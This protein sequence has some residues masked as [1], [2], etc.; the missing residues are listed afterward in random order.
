MPNRHI[1]ELRRAIGQL[2]EE[3]TRRQHNVIIR[4]QATRAAFVQLDDPPAESMK[5]LRHAAFL[6][7]RTSAK[8]YQVWL[9]LNE[10]PDLDFKRRLKEGAGAD[11]MATGATR[12]AGSFN[13]KREYGPESTT[14]RIGDF[15][16]PMVKI[17]H[18]APSQVTTRAAMESLGIL[19]A[20]KPPRPTPVRVSLASSGVRKWPSYRKCLDGAPLNQAATGPDRSRADYVWCKTALE[21]GIRSGHPWSAEEVAARL[22]Q[23][24]EKARERGQDY[25]LQTVRSAAASVERE[26]GQARARVEAP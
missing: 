3:A 18:A 15:I 7:H 11:I 13:F 6:I 5:R 26:S 4:P 1:S 25:A 14:A 8:G 22:M 17:I 9:A 12:I 21:W 2:L 23:E 16:Y 24:S 20:P 19:A 10:K